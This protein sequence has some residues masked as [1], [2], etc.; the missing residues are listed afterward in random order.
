MAPPS[1][2][3]KN[4]SLHFSP[5]AASRRRI[6]DHKT[7]WLAGVCALQAGA[8][9]LCA[10][11]WWLVAGGPPLWACLLAR[12]IRDGASNLLSFVPALGEA[13]A[14]RTLGVIGGVDQGQS[15]ASTIADAA[16]ESMAQAIYTLIGLIML[17][18]ALR[19]GDAPRWIG[20]VAVA[21]VPLA[22]LCV[23]SSHA[24]ALGLA[25]RL[26][27]RL[28][29][30]LGFRPIR[31]ADA[32]QAIFRRRAQALLSLAVH[33]LAW[34]FGAAQV[35]LAAQALGRP[36]DF[37]AALALESLVYVARSAFFLVPWAAGV[38]EGGFLLVG[39]ALG[40][41][42]SSAIALSFV[43]RARDV[44]LGAPGIVLWSVV[45]GRVKL[46]RGRSMAA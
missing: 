21:L 7:A 14:S 34:A 46:R 2:R 36:L 13:M 44:L 23:V 35:W 41:E 40:L 17:L 45:E 32:V 19:S 27:G 30:L 12:W 38:Q 11:A 29:R 9:A 39:G 6:A 25:E 28:L 8:L 16:I 1:L 4:Q 24:G 33:L 22:L 37:A 20:I 15:A 42:P 43:L 31:F 18:H 26:L 5:P 10:V 3:P